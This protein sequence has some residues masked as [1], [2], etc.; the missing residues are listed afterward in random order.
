MNKLSFLVLLLLPLFSVAQKLS[1]D[2][3]VEGLPDGTNILLVDLENS[4]AKIDETKSKGGNFKLSGKLAGPGILG[5]M[6]GDSM[7]TA[8]FLGNENVKVVGSIK[9][10]IDDWKYN[11]S[12]NQ[13][14]FM[15]FQDQFIPKFEKVDELGKALQSG[16]GDEKANNEL[17]ATVEDIQTG[18]DK[19]IKE[20]PTSPVSAMV[21]LSTIGFTDDVSI[22]EKR[23]AS[24]S[25]E[26]INSSIGKQL[27][28]AVEDAKFNSV[29]TVPP[30]FTQKDADGKEVKL[31]DFKG[32]YV[33]VDF[34]ASWCG[35]CRRENP[36]VV[37]V[38]EK[39]KDKN[40][41]VLG[42]SLDEDKDAWLGA[43]KK[44]GLNWTQVSDLKGWE[45]A[46]AQQYR[47]SAIPRNFLLGPDGKILA[48]DLRGED[49][50]AK[51]TDILGKK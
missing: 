30:D 18:V 2:G 42:V 26:A 41:T 25:G 4:A 11:G 47:I 36:N 5:L 19:F 37:K 34:W 39:F 9:Q 33:L 48:K 10:H 3:T 29:G 28:K 16:M 7:K 24:L 21:I 1:L 46:V 38:F 6:V 8:V 20:H 27:G 23:I 51:L 12:P 45:N 43:V 49:L 31:S 44:D 35:P 17:K 15:E 40:F 14:A 32:K 22:I 13:T 50:E